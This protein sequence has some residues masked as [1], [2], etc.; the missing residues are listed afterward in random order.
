M[1]V[2]DLLGASAKPVSAWAG[3]RLSMLKGE[4]SELPTPI[5]AMPGDASQARAVSFSYSVDRNLR[6]WLTSSPC[7]AYD[8][9]TGVD[10]GHSF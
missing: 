4:Q 7:K 5:A 9:L 1:A 2:F 8:C 10:Y 3:S 6:N